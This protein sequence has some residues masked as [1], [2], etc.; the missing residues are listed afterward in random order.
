MSEKSKQEDGAKAE[1]LEKIDGLRRQ[2]DEA[3]ATIVETINRRLELAEAIG[4]IKKRYGM[5]V[6][7]FARERKVLDRLKSLN[8]GP[9]P[10]ETLRYLYSEIMAASRR[11]QKPVQVSFF[12]PEATFTHLAAMNHFGHDTIY[13]PQPSIADVFDEVEKNKSAFGVVPVENSIE[14]AVNHT[15]DLFLTSELKICAEIYAPIAQDLLSKETSPEDVRIIYSH[16]Q[17]LAQCRAWLRRNMPEA[18]LKECASTSE[19]AKMAAANPGSAAIGSSLAA[20]VYD[21]IVLASHIQDVAHN[22]TRFLVIG[23]DT[24]SRTGTDKTS[25]LFAT[26]HVPGALYRVL[27]PI[28]ESGINMVK[29]ESRPAKNASW[30][31]LFFVDVEGHMEDPSIKEMFGEMQRTCAFIKCLGSYPQGGGR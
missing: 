6:V 8:K 25:F 14:G 22:V 31:Y 23:R 24:M 2:I 16:P 21:L 30:H 13:T 26:P 7:D 11:I 4:R 10:Q 17:A 18:A 28:A 9:L 3:D 5:Q 20:L 1:D 15:L 27:A 29:L 19:A 12:G